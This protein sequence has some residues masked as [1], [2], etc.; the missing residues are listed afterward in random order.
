M[1]C[2]S[3]RELVHDLE[4]P[5]S[6]EPEAYDR[7]IEHAQICTPCARELDRVRALSEALRAVAA[8]DERLFASPALEAGVVRAFRAWSP[9]PRPRTRAA[10]WIGAAASLALAA[11]VG[12][13]W[14]MSAARPKPAPSAPLSELAAAGPSKSVP[15][16]GLSPSKPSGPAQTRRAG[17]AEASPAAIPGFDELA[18][19]IPLPFAADESPLGAGELVRIRL[20]ESALSLLGVPVS[21]NAS[22]E[23]VT[24]DVVIGEDGVAR[25][26]RF[27]SGPVPP[28]L[29]Q[30]IESASLTPKGVHQ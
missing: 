7:A 4:R 22:A 29:E 12:T 11:G 20:S 23:P 21:E 26:I 17:Q 13:L 10:W 15:A 8:A 18:D 24:A 3:F 2:T 14:K 25:A 16:R 1:N 19:F 9:V 6:V 27:V 30:S 28:E 5:E